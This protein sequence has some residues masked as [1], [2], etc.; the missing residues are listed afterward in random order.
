M[1]ISDRDRRALTLGVAV[2]AVI[3]AY[4]LFD[5]Y[6]LSWYDAMVADHAVR[7]GK[8]AKG[9]SDKKEAMALSSSIAEWEEKAG[10]LADP[11]AYSE[12]S[13]KV[14]EQIITAAQK[15]GV[16]LKNVNVT[17]ASAWPEDPKL[18]MASF[19]IEG[20]TEWPKVF[21][22]IAGL[23]HIPGVLSVEQIKL[24]TGKDGGKLAAEMTLSFL[25][26]AARQGGGLWAR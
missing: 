16:N 14:H 20:E 23:Y 10:S 1:V 3:G 9:I 24:S 18:Q 17:A 25:V 7:A 13:T 22:F 21:E 15:N 19:H 26:E 8:V 11:P 2:L 6:V 12:Q 4:L 5:T